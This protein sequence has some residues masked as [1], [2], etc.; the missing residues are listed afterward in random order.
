MIKGK[1]G[2]NLTKAEIGQFSQKNAII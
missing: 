2:E 1:F